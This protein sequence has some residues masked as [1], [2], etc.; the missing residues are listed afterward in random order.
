[1]PRQYRLTT[2]RRIVNAITAFLVRIGVYPGHTYLLTVRG[3]TTGQPYTTPVT[4]VVQ[5]SERWLVAPYGPV[6]WVRNARVAGE[7]TLTHGRRREVVR[8]VELGPEE[9]APV[10]RQYL[11]EVPVVRPFFAATPDAALEAFVAE[12]AAHPVF[13]IA[14]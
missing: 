3:R 13:R 12:A 6:A 1:M 14:A 4:L 2:G 7:V 8:V 11:R 5:G 10:L 9:S